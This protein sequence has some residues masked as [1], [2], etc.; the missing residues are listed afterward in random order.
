MREMTAG[1][2][3]MGSRLSN[4]AA[5]WPTF[6]QSVVIVLVLVPLYCVVEETSHVFWFTPQGIRFTA[7][8]LLPRRLWLA[9]LAGL[10]LS[11]IV[12]EW[13][14][15]LTWTESGPTLQWPFAIFPQSLAVLLA[16]WAFRRKVEMT[17]PDSPLRMGLLLGC[18]LSA[19]ILAAGCDELYGWSWIW[20]DGEF[21]FGLLNLAI[22]SFTGNIGG[23]LMIAPLA[24]ALCYPKA[25]S[26]RRTLLLD[27]SFGLALPLTLVAWLNLVNADPMTSDYSRVLVLLPALYLGYRHGW[28]GAALAISLIGLALAPI[29]VG[30][31]DTP[32]A[33]ATTHML[34]ALGGMAALL[35]GAAMD[36]QRE[37]HEQLAARNRE[38]QDAGAA[39]RDAAQRNLS[40]EEDQRRKFAA[41]LHDEL[42]QNL[43]A[44]QTRIK[45]A[46]PYLDT[47]QA[48][49][50]TES[51]YA[52]L[53][54]MR[55]S[56]YGLMGQL[57]PAELDDFGLRR[58]LA[59]GAIREHVETA[60]LRFGFDLRGDAALIAALSGD[61]QL[62]LYRIA[63]EAATNT[64]KH[65]RA[66]RFDVCLRLARRG[67]T[68]LA[69]LDVRDNGAGFAS[70][71]ESTEGH[72]GLRGL[73][74][75]V[76]A[77][78]GVLRVS[79]DSSGTRLHALL[80]QQA[81]QG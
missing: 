23:T 33:R 37:S 51:I 62:A 7:F 65:A 9:A 15:Y 78:N 58:A 54:T 43:T 26:S 55:R 59:E 81:E 46:E 45:L 6:V 47:A 61:V 49:E 64:I 36:A 25:L 24:L 13:Y 27:G 70:V 60:G 40:L 22:A 44:V 11:M 52:I 77:L 56:V 17:P 28:R 69:L 35:L 34:F 19:A 63:Q 80:R 20:S 8:L 57:R 5:S 14:I 32:D 1:M 67:N 3:R 38:L 41:E 72:F 48:G 75:R 4:W 12:H 68:A 29:H 79:S 10:W 53:A 73:R 42:G 74:D 21:K 31:W 71:Q 30:H 76:T 50:V 16:V 18:M 39:L 66:S 2:Q